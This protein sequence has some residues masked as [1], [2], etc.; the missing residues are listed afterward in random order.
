MKR[1]TL[2]AAQ[3]AL[4]RRAAVDMQGRTINGSQTYAYP[5][6][7]RMGKGKPMSAII[8]EALKNGHD[9]AMIKRIQELADMQ[10]QQDQQ[11]SQKYWSPLKNPMSPSLSDMEEKRLQEEYAKRKKNDEYF[12]I[13]YPLG[14]IDGV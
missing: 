1:N 11:Q 2:T 4:K 14:G 7:R 9:P 3:E 10:Q 5:G 13:R 12:R 6:G 8:A